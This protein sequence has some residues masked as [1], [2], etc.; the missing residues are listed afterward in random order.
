MNI[1]KRGGKIWQTAAEIVAA[2]AN[3]HDT[4]SYA[5]IAEELNYYSLHAVTSMG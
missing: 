1:G 2:G 5:F 3:L 4:N